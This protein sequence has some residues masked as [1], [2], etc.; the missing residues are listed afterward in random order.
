MRGVRPVYRIGRDLIYA[1]T[2]DFVRSRA[3]ADQAL[4]IVRKWVPEHASSLRYDAWL[5]DSDQWTLQGAQRSQMPLQRIALDDDQDTF[6]YVAEWSGEIVMKTDRSSR[7]KGFWSGVLHWV[8][9]VP[10]RKHGYA[11]NQFIIWGSFAGGLMCL[12]GLGIGVWRLS[13]SG[14][15]RQKRQASHTPYSG[16]MRWHHYSGLLFGLLTFTWIISGAFSVNPFGMFSGGQRLTREQREV[17]TGGPVNFDPVSLDAMSKGVAAIG[18]HF[19]AKEIDV[20]QFRG[21]L[22]LAAE[23][24]PS[25]SNPEVG[26]GPVDHRMVWLARP[27]D[28]TF[29]KFENSVMED[30]AEETMAGV[31]VQDSE[32]LHEYDNYYRSRDNA[33][34]L[35]VLRV[36]Y[37]DDQRSWLY[38]DPQRGTV[39]QQTRFSRM[40]RWLYNALHEF[41]VPFLYER[42]PLWDLAVILLSIGGNVLSGSTLWAMVKRLRRHGRRFGKLM[43]PTWRVERLQAGDQG[44]S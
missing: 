14:R 43:R 30:I 37:L 3:D 18:E 11:W 12:T 44:N 32:W 39:S 23:S 19:P 20:R 22:Y 38:L 35:P 42:R 27:E 5:E 15:F 25:K 34:P 16:L 31:P 29:T 21:E 36:R 24:P 13:M 1:D 41:D 10:L 9:F 6:Y 28:G 33:R 8:Y 4:E 7:F 40:R 2:G 26:T 17:L